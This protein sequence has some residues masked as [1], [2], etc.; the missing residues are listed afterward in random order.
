VT[1]SP[2]RLDGSTVLVT[3]GS[4]GIGKRLALDMARLGARVAIVA[5]DEPRLY[6]TEAEL[7]LLSPDALALPCDVTRQDD[8]DRVVAAIRARLGAVDILVNNAGYAVYRTFEETAIDEIC[9]LADVNL[10]GAMR[11]IRALLPGMIE[12]RQ[13]RIVNMS[14]IAGRIPL[15]PNSVYCASKHGLV[16]LSEALRYELH[17]FGVRVHVICPGRVETPFFD[18][19]TFRTRAAR[20]ETRYTVTLQAVSRATLRAIETGR[21]MTYV[22]WT[23]GLLAWSVNA[24]PWLTRPLL[25]RLMMARVRSYYGDGRGAGRRA[26]DVSGA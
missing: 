19:E 10:V 5:R 23:L 20:V 4:S 1:R 14:S 26:R 9:R 22:P 8:V 11:C 17:D 3:G 12:R 6:E 18:H 21:F 15:T 16:A 25:R 2:G 7:R 13:G 24:L